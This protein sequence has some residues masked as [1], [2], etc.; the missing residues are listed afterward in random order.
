MLVNLD[1]V[2]FCQIQQSTTTLLC[3]MMFN[4]I[5]MACALFGFR[6]ELCIEKIVNI[7]ESNISKCNTVNSNKLYQMYW[8]KTVFKKH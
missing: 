4:H 2:I 7:K 1:D 3:S 5:K 8:K 6:L